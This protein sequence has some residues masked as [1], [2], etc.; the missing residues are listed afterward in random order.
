MG[1]S[2]IFFQLSLDSGSHWDFPG[3]SDG[4]ESACNAGDRGLIPGSEDA[5]E[6]GMVTHSS[7]PAWRMPW[8]EGAGGLQSMGLQ[9]VGHD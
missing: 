3:D 1:E 8:T 9:V 4:K 7:I 2:V 5:L 6:E